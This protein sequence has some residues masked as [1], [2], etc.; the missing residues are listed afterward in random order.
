MIGGW[1]VIPAQWAVSIMFSGSPRSAVHSPLL[2]Q[3]AGFSPFF[4]QGRAEYP[5]PAPFFFSILLPGLLHPPGAPP[6]F[7]TP[8]RGHGLAD[9]L[10][11]GARRVQRLIG[12]FFALIVWSPA[13]VFLFAGEHTMFSS[14]YKVKEKFSHANKTGSKKPRKT[15][16]SGNLSLLFTPVAIPTSPDPE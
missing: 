8:C 13:S 5:L 7:A 16:F 10:G 11:T 2:M 14:A 15:G 12:G 4:E 1:S 6:L 3:Q 9:R